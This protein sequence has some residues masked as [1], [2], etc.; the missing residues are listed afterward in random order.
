MRR[1]CNCGAAVEVI[2]RGFE[3]VVVVGVFG[4]ILCCRDCN[5]SDF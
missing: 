4:E 3:S 1:V 5:L 2:A